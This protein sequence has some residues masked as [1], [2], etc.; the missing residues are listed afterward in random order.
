MATMT[1]KTRDYVLLYSTMLRAREALGPML[2]C[3]DA[4]P[5]SVRLNEV[6]NDDTNRRRLDQSRRRRFRRKTTMK[7]RRLS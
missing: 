1:G 3:D 4:S 7:R 6:I 5:L 2:A